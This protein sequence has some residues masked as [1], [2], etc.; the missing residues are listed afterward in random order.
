[1]APSSAWLPALRRYF[2]VIVVGNLAWESAQLPLYTLWKAGSAKEIIFAVFHCT[3]GDMLIAGA[4]LVVSLLVLGTAEWPRARFL[5]VV[6]TTLI[7]GVGIT[8]YSEHLNTVRGAWTYSDLMPVLPGTGI[9]VA[10][11]AQW[12]VIPILAFAAARSVIFVGHL[13]LP[14][15]GITTS[16]VASGDLARPGRRAS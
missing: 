9:G 10:P 8:A 2:C 16:G 7:S 12:L 4:T 14:I 5:S 1:M 6:V 13:D 3:G 15:M 11:L